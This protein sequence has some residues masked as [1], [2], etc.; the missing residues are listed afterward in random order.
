MAVGALVV[1]HVHG[2][3]AEIVMPIVR[4]RG[5]TAL[6]EF[7]QVFE[8]QRLGFLNTDR[9]GGVAREDVGHALTES[10]DAHQVGYFVGDIDELN[11]RMSLEHQPPEPRGNAQRVN[12]YR[13][14]RARKL[15]RFIQSFPKTPYSRRAERANSMPS[16]SIL[17]L[18]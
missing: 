4:L 7:A 15:H 18:Y 14:Y 5:R 11:G 6:Q 13:R 12:P 2:A 1:V 9:G 17:S 3:D 8:Q 10:A 16:T